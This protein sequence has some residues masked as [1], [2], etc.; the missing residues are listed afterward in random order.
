MD[1]N[2]AK[3]AALNDAFR[4]AMGEGV[5]KTQGINALPVADQQQISEKIKLQQD[6]GEANDPYG[7]HNFGAIQH[8]DQKIFWKID[9]Y[10]NTR[11]RASE[12]PADPNKTS[13]V[14]TIML[15]NEY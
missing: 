7:E 5:Y 14:M 8:N 4:Q 11:S 12:D 9:Y 1:D 10:N 2:T 13:R 15:A 3:I 6:F